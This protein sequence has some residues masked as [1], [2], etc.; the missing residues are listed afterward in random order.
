MIIKCLRSFRYAFHGIYQVTKNENNAKI[1]LLASGMVIGTGC[2]FKIDAKDW[3]WLLLAITLVW[4]T[5]AVNSSIEKLV[6]M[7]SPEYH[8]IAG[9]VKDIAAGAVLIAAFFALAVAT[10]IF[11]PYIN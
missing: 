8:P 10:I 2:Y 4:I 6:D 11:M 9:K 5:E 3:L 1:H 7:V